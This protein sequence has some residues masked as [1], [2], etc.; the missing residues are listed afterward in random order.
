M[1]KN[2]ECV[3]QCF[4]DYA[5]EKQKIYLKR[6]FIFLEKRE[7]TF[8]ILYTNY[9]NIIELSGLSWLLDGILKY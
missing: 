1:G 6:T 8:P 4:K 3:I 9:N 2:I 7:S 5:N